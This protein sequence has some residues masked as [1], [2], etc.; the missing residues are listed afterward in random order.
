M[1]TGMANHTTIK[2]LMFMPENLC[3]QDIPSCRKPFI[4]SIAKQ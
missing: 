3:R 1:E 2:P 4:K